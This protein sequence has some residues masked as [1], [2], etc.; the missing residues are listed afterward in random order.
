MLVYY[1]NGWIHL[2]IGR[3]DRWLRWG[4]VE[5]GVTVLLFVLVLPWGPAGIAIAWT[6]SFWI[7]VLPAFWYA[8]RPIQFGIAP[9]VAALWKYVL[10]SLVAGCA[11]ALIL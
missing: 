2:S 7:L 4:F 6:A 11:S 9:I 1:S 8:G 3:P 10:A 5:V